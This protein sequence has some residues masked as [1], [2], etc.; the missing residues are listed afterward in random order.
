MS[1]KNISLFLALSVGALSTSMHAMNINV[2][3]TCYRMQKNDAA[4]KF[5][6]YK[7]R[8]EELV[9]K[10]K[11]AQKKKSKQQLYTTALSL[12]KD[13]SQLYYDFLTD[14]SGGYNLHQEV[15]EGKTF[16]TNKIEKLTDN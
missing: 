6:K 8:A 15:T 13:A 7:T 14:I 11:K 9:E 2:F 5:N 3:P 16:C 12:Y 1:Y 10:A 4:F